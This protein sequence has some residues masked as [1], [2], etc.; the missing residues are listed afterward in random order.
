MFAFKGFHGLI[1][2]SVKIVYIISIWVPVPLSFKVSLTRTHT[3]VHRI[4]PHGRF[5]VYRVPLIRSCPQ[6]MGEESSAEENPDAWDEDGEEGEEE[7]QK[8]TDPCVAPSSS[9]GL[10]KKTSKAEVPQENTATSK[11][12]AA[13]EETGQIK[14][15]EGI[16]SQLP[17]RTSPVGIPNSTGDSAST[18]T[19]AEPMGSWIQFRYC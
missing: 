12:A 14:V 1:T 10:K 17:V 13:H 4:F 2:Q 16:G 19:S 5:V 18:A 15:D 11:Q 9:S 6:V 3:N 7:E 8:E